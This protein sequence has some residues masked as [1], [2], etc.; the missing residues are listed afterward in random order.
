MTAKLNKRFFSYLDDIAAEVKEVC[1]D[2]Y[3]RAALATKL[4]IRF[5]PELSRVQ[6]E[7]VVDTWARGYDAA[8]SEEYD[9]QSIPA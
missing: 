7:M 3:L 6:A 9:Q 5:W 2:P 8:A 1:Q 4:C